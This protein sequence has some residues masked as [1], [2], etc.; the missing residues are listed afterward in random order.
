MAR[1]EY[2]VTRKLS[3]RV[4]HSEWANVPN[5]RLSVPEIQ[6]CVD[7]AC[8][9]GGYTMAVWCELCG[10]NVADCPELRGKLKRVPRAWSREWDLDPTAEDA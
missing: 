2:Q 9:N 1:T 8:E 6:A 4:D 5:L 7:D 10:E 3:T